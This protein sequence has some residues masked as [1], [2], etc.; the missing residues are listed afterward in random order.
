MAKF[1]VEELIFFLQT[2]LLD[3]VADEDDDAFQGKRL[4]DEVEG[5]EFCGADRGLDGAVAGDDD[6]AR[7]LRKA[8]DAAEGFHAVHAGEPDV[9]ENHF[10]GGGVE[11]LEGEFSG[12]NGFDGVALV[13]EDGGERLADAGFVIHDEDFGAGAHRIL[14]SGAMSAPMR[15][16][17]AA[18]GSSTTGSSIRKREPRGW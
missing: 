7:G 11:A 1:G 6:D 18:A 8:L 10:D 3:G 12:F 17:L 2:A 14:S 16:A 9:E 4:F 15:S 5:A 13:A